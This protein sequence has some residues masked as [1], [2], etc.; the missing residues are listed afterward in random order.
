MAAL[1]SEMTCPSRSSIF[2]FI[3]S[4]H[5]ASQ[6]SVVYMSMMS[7]VGPWVIQRRMSLRPPSPRAREMK[8]LRKS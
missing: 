4:L 5:V 7:V 1:G 6:G 8:V 3:I 2:S